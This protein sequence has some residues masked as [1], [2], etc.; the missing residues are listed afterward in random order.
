M[1]A[2]AFLDRAAKSKRQPVY[3]LAGEEDFLR[4][5]CRDAIVALVLG[6]ADPSFA[7]SSYDG[8]KLDFS[9]VRNDLETLPFLAPARVVIVEQADA[10]VT[11]H[12]PALEKYVAAPSK[13]GVL[14]LEVK[15]FPETTK[16][17][18]ALPDA[19]KIACKAPKE[20]HLPGWCAGWARAGHGKQLPAEA[21]ELL[22][23]LVGPSMGLIDQ[24]LAKL[25]VA[26][27]EKPRIDAEEV[28]AYVGRSRSVD[29]FK[30]LDAVG[31]EQ[32]AR[33][34]HLLAR[35]FEEGEDPLAILGPLTYQLRKL[36][37]ANRA[38]DRG[39]TAGQ[40]MDAAG[41]PTWPKIRAGFERQLRHIGRRRLAKI[42][43]WLV[44]INLG[45][46]GG[47]PL[48][49][50]L[51]LERLIVRLARPRDPVPGR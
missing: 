5:R 45:L 50:R 34:L 27:G 42:P 16:L 11:E 43:G 31:D 39:L 38:L 13:I 20:E 19:A 23:E 1:D 25:A 48:P 37:A 24:E 15:S 28:D 49:P 4:R 32:P 36:A 51:Q 46:K 14:V 18:K 7:V 40:A 17:A 26:V 6:D 44:E 41:V 35:L 21:A 47:S 10:F 8:E 3:V 22:V 30:I 29:V 2:L 12:R 33:A 9:A